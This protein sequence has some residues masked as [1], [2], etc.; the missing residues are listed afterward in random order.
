MLY[1][2]DYNWQWHLTQ[3]GRKWA[4]TDHLRRLLMVC[5]TINLPKKEKKIVTN[6][7]VTSSDCVTE[8]ALFV[9]QWHYSVWNNDK[10]IFCHNGL[11]LNQLKFG[12]KISRS[13]FE[14]KNDVIL[15]LR[16]FRVIFSVTS[17]YVFHYKLVASD[18]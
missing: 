3:F 7:L 18:K 12:L 13:F 17:F 16:R 1:F 15:S 8:W 5:S 11:S 2:I 9:T 6:L 10:Q 14:P 4:G